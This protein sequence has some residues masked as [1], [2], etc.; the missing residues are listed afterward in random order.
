MNSVCQH[1]Q[2]TPY[3]KGASSLAD[4]GFS[5]LQ[6]KDMGDWSSLA[7]LL[8]IVKSLTAKKDLDKEM[9]VKVFGV[10]PGEIG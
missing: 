1:C 8:Y 6:I 4:A 2:P 7:A 5:L 9:Y 3:G 10:L